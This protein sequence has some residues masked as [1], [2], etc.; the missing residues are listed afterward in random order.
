MDEILESFN[1][2]PGATN[3]VISLAENQLKLKLPSEYVEFLKT[4]NGGEGW[5][6]DSYV[7]LWPASDLAPLNR[8]YESNKGMPGFLIYGSNGGGE[9]F[10]FDVR[11]PESP[12]LQVPF[13]GI[14]WSDARPLGASFDEFLQNLYAGNQL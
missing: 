5:I 10:G 11:G 7:I 3:E 2:G 12:I 8:S 13:I 4:G 1:L 6:G 9:A 14:S